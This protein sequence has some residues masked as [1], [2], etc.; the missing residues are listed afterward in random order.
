MF[1]IVYPL[2][3]TAWTQIIVFADKAF[4]SHT[5]KRLGPTYITANT[6]MRRIIYRSREL[7]MLPGRLDIPFGLGILLITPICAFRWLFLVGVCFT[8][9]LFIVLR[10]FCIKSDHQSYSYV[11]TRRQIINLEIAKSAWSIVLVTDLVLRP[12]QQHYQIENNNK[13]FI[14]IQLSSRFIHF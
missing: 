3:N 4:E 2:F 1:T 11:E 6:L 12:I 7:N 10:K 14:I 5:N 9:G 8:A 13:T